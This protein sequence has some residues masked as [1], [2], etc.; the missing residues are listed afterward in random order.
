MVK[1]KADLAASV[2]KQKE[3]TKQVKQLE[4]ELTEATQVLKNKQLSYDAQL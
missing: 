4:K 1:T 2:D 3:A